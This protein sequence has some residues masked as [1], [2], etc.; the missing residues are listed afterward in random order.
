M[1]FMEWLFGCLMYKK[2]LQCFKLL[3]MMVLFVWSAGRRKSTFFR[4]LAINDDWFADDLRRL[5]DKWGIIRRRVSFLWGE[6]TAIRY[7]LH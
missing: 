4:F 6:R 3:D 5:E 2:S 7:C 1:S